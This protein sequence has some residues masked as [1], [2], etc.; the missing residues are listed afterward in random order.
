MLYGIQYRFDEVF[1]YENVNTAKVINLG[2]I[3][4]FIGTTCGSN[5]ESASVIFYK[6]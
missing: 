1:F 6:V 2:P 4:M 3:M 5:A